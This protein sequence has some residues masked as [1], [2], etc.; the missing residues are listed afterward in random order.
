[1]VSAREKR[2]RWAWQPPARHPVPIWGTCGHCPTPVPRDQVGGLGGPGRLRRRLGCRVRGWQVVSRGQNA[3]ER[4][5]LGSL[6]SVRGGPASWG[7]PGLGGH[8]QRAGPQGRVQ[9]GRPRGQGG[10]EWGPTPKPPSH[11]ASSLCVQVRPSQ[12][13]RQMQE[14]ESPLPTQVPPFT[15]G[16]GRQLL[17]LA[18]GGGRIFH[19]AL[20]RRGPHTPLPQTGW[21]GPGGSSPMLQVLPLQPGGQA[22]RKVSPLS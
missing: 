8:V 5:R 22:Q 19:S 16:L 17:F 21:P 12:P 6:G 14:K 2:G 13:S 3:R 20:G 11:S 18:V 7:L 1:M 4:P 9:G 15:Q 10:K